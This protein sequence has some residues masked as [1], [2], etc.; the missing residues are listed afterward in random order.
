MKI[1]STA[2]SRF[3]A[4]RTSNSASRSCARTCATPPT[5]SATNACA[6]SP[7]STT[8]SNCATRAPRS[9]P[10]YA[11]ACPS[12]WR[13]SRRTRPPPARRCTGPATPTR[14]AGSSS[15]LAT[16]AGVDQ[17][18]KVKSM[19]TQ[20]IG[21]N[22]ALAADGI[23]AYETDLAELIVQLAGDTPSHILVPAIHYNRTEIRDIFRDEMPGAP[24]GL[25]TTRPPSP[26]SLGPTCGAGSSRPASRSPART[27]PSPTAAPWSSSRARA[28]AACA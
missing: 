18:V 28:T 12:C 16:A 26:A 10:T 9:R 4:R 8:G 17:L 27:S 5:P 23:S 7:N 24:E 21:L 1:R 13:P 15:D 6:S 3:P 19:A 22:E 25:P 14:P 2:G 11:G 20:E